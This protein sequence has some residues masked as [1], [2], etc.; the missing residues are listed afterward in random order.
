MGGRRP[1]RLGRRACRCGRVMPRAED[2]G[3]A[4]AAARPPRVSLGSSHAQG[5]GGGKIGGRSLRRRS[6][7]GA[8]RSVFPCLRARC[9]VLFVW[10]M[11]A[12][13][14]ALRS[15]PG[16]RHSTLRTR[17]EGLRM[18][19]P[20]TPHTA[21]GD[22]H[23]VILCALLQPVPR[24]M[25][26]V[27]GQECYVIYYNFRLPPLQTQGFMGA[28]LPSAGRWGGRR[29]RC[30]VALLCYSAAARLR[31]CAPRGGAFVLPG[32]RA[33]GYRAAKMPAD[34]RLVASSP[35]TAL[36]RW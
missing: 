1:L 8:M 31:R 3:T 33:A 24:A 10:V 26:A 27:F 15:M 30:G 19:L 32:R 7:V 35:H 29:R 16:A 34:C 4:P 2:G 20:P 12:V 22:M 5:A 21:V 14:C 18:L 23:D 9:H 11:C 13:H 25:C 17:N 6:V 28:L 36:G